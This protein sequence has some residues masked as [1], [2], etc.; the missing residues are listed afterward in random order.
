VDRRRVGDAG[1]RSTLRPNPPTVHATLLVDLPVPA[2]VA[3]PECVATL[4]IAASEH[5]ALK[6]PVVADDPARHDPP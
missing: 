3:R 4:L 6:R 2:D 1:E 5:A